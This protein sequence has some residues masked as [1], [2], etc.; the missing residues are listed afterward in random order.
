VVTTVDQEIGVRAGKQPLA[1]LA[2]TNFLAQDFGASR[3]QGAVF[4]ENAIPLLVGD[5]AV[6]DEVEIVETKLPYQ[7]K[8]RGV[9]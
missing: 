4:G 5:I 1:T 9:V 8:K 2:A 6:G 7:F 3:V